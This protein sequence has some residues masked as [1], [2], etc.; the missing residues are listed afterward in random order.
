[1]ALG[2]AGMDQ[3]RLQLQ[4]LQQLHQ[5]APAVGRLERDRSAWRQR[6]KDRDQLGRIVG[7]VAVV[8][9]DAGVIQH[10]DLGTLAVE[11]HPDIDTHQGLG[12]R[13]RLVPE[14]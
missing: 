8:L 3:V 10:R 6:A 13:A 9:L 12:P 11:V 2:A 1:M 7:E 4:L 5:P 14:A